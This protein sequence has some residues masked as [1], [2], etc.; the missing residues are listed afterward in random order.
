MSD[1]KHHFEP[2]TWLRGI[3]AFLVV[4]SHTLRATQDTYLEND[5]P[6]NWLILRILDL[7]TFGVLLFFTLS[8][9]TLYL[10]HSKQQKKLS[11]VPFYIKR[12]F[13]IW[14][15]FAL[16]L[17]VY[18]AF[19]FVF[20]SYYGEGTG[21]WVEQQFLQLPSTVDFVSYLTLSFNVSGHIGLFNNAYWSLPVEFQYYLL[22]PVIILLLPRLK[23]LSPV[24]IGVALY[25][26]FKIDLGL[27]NDR[28]VLML[29]FTFCGGVLLGYLYRLNEL[30]LN[31]YLG[32]C[33]F[34]FF[35]ASASAV[36]NQ[37][38]DIPNIPVI[39]NQWIMLGL[40]ALSVVA[41]ILFSEIKL[42][43]FFTRQFFK[44]GELSYSLYLYHNL[45]IGFAVLVLIKLNVTDGIARYLLVLILGG[46]VSVFVAYRSYLHVE[47]PFMRIGS[48]LSRL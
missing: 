37:F 5:E 9:T 2:L 39:S 38:I 26:M 40:I 15:A 16:S 22:F 14:P 21:N 33:L 30:R 45:L 43:K 44:L 3:A 25:L 4:I 41:C 46:G 34:I 8:G 13:R 18:Y 1:Q 42:P 48:R 31:P 19:S 17:M 7:G 27:F 35:F 32:T 29:G 24:I 6:V 10:S 36:T 23:L 47:L 20:R 11:V 12:F 28:R